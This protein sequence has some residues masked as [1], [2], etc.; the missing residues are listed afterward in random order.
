VTVKAAS[1]N[2]SIRCERVSPPCGLAST[3]PVVLTASTQR[4]ALAAETPNRAAAAHAIRNSGYQAG[5]K[6]DGQWL[7]HASWPPAKHA[8]SITSHPCRGIPNDSDR[9]VSAL[10]GRNCGAVC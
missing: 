5:T 7:T 6:V 10:S 3:M 2:A 9:V 1:L 8:W 4:T